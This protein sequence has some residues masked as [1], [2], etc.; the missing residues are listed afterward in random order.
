MLQSILLKLKS[1]RG[2][3]RLEGWRM[4]WDGRQSIQH[5]IRPDHVEFLW[6]RLSMTEE[7]DDDG[8]R[9][10]AI[11]ALS[12]LGL[13]LSLG[14][15]PTPEVTVNLGRMGD[16]GSLANWLW[17]PFRGN[18]AVFLLDDPDRF[19][20][21]A[22][23]HILLARRLSATDYPLVQHQPISMTD[24]QWSIVV[25]QRGLDAICLVG[26]LGL[27][28]TE[29]LTRWQD[30]GARFKFRTHQ[31]PA[32]LGHGDLHPDWHCIE[33]LRPDGTRRSFVT[34]DVGSERTDY[35]LVQRYRVLDG[36]REVVIVNCAGG[37]TLGTLAAVRWASETLFQPTQFQGDPIQVPGKVDSA[38][39]LEVLMRVRAKISTSDFVDT[40]V[41]L[42]HL[43]V[44]DSE[45]CADERNWVSVPPQCIT[46][47][48]QDG[49]TDKP[50]KILLDGMDTR[51]KSTSMSFHL[52]WQLA[53]LAREDQ[54]HAG[55]PLDKLVA[56]LKVPGKQ[57]DSLTEAN[58][59]RK[60]STLKDR[61]FGKAITVGDPVGVHAKVVIESAPVGMTVV[62][63]KSRRPGPGTSGTEDGPPPGVVPRPKRKP[64]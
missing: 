26:R 16:A 20:R 45:W 23:A 29:A 54:S 4:L 11:K 52:A 63:N 19:R 21:D 18:S 47:V 50:V 37:S 17:L 5:E 61:H 6:D 3:E 58:V 46:L 43:A 28:G 14:R 53:V 44:G 41:D 25:R 15:E 56:D 24:P 9:H 34:R 38:S 62:A 55:I 1:Q 22:F 59:R 10:A 12:M 31:R 32:E 36:T 49:Q 30:P 40:S 35:G 33:E 51:M 42:L 7:L 64:K 8:E 57:T 13:F 48:C 2:A 39:R 60:L 27:Y